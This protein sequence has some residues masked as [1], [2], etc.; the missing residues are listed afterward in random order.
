MYQS[1]TLAHF[2]AASKEAEKCPGGGGV[3]HTSESVELVLSDIST[4]VYSNNHHAENVQKC[5]RGQ[6]CK[7]I[8]IPSL[9]YLIWFNN[10]FI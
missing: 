3:N 8:T 5:P 9:P 2:F 10:V 1:E 7:Y 6:T 4:L